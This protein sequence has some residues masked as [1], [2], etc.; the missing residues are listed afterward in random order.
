LLPAVSTILFDDGLAV[1][2]VGRGLDRGQNGEV[3]AERLV[4]EA[5]AARDL[6]GQILWRRLGQ[7][8]DEAE[9]AGIGNGC[10]QFGAPHPLHAALHDR[11][12]DPDKLGE[13]CSDH[14]N[15]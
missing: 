13:A 3:D 5:A 12:F 8:G 2:G 4:G 14:C 1:F 11:V 15:P 6:L 9:R 10:D 7:R